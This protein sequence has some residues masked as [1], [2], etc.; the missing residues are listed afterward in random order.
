MAITIASEG[1]GNGSTHITT[2]V[3]SL[4]KPATVNNDDYLVA[5]IGKQNDPDVAPPVGWTTGEEGSGTAGNDIFC[6]VYY[7]KITDAAGEPATYEFDS[8]GTSESFAYWIGSLTGVDLTTPEDVDFDTG[9]GAFTYLEGDTSPNAPAVTTVTDNA[10]ALA[11]W[12]VSGDSTHTSPGAPWSLRADNINGALHVVSQIISP[13]GTTGSPEIT[14][15]S[16]LADS[17]QGMFVFRPA[18]AAPSTLVQD[19]IL[20]SGVVPFAR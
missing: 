8:A 1:T 7:K 15:V 16:T 14:G 5:I 4:T 17:M 20:S 19:P 12:D 6:G 13:A 3:F 18:G 2:G 10:F 11:V 9:T